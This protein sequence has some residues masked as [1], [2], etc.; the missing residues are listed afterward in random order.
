[1]PLAGARVN[2][3]RS[4]VCRGGSMSKREFSQWILC[5]SPSGRHLGPLSFSALATATPDR[6]AQ[7]PSP[8]ANR[9]T[10]LEA[11]RRIH[12]RSLSGSL[13]ERPGTIAGT[14]TAGFSCAWKYPTRI[15]CGHRS[16]RRRPRFL[17]RQNHGERNWRIR[18]LHPEQSERPRGSLR[19]RMATRRDLALGLETGRRPQSRARN[20]RLRAVVRRLTCR[21]PSAALSLPT[22]LLSVSPG[23]AVMP[24]VFRPDNS[25]PRT[26]FSH[27]RLSGSPGLGAD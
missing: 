4:Q 20:F 8:G 24:A 27:T 14:V 15:Q 25:G 1:M 16:P 3:N 9:E 26:S 10:Q 12:R 23:R 2:R 13:G 22:P 19:I 18:R 17:E 11:G 6:A 7:R 5:R 21:A